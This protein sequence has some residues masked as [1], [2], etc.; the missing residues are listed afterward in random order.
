MGKSSKFFR[1]S[2]NGFRFE[3][4]QYHMEQTQEHCQKDPS[5]FVHVERREFFQK[6]PLENLKMFL[7]RETKAVATLIPAE[8]PSFLIAPAGK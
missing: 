6:I 4:P 2:E 5:T 1:A 7:K 8:G 3:Y